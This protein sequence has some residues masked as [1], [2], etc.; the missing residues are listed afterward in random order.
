MAGPRH[1]GRRPLVHDVAHIDPLHAALPGG[2]KGRAGGVVEVSLADQRTVGVC[3]FD[4][5][6][7]RQRAQ[8]LCAYLHAVDCTCGIVYCS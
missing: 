4:G 6:C 8:L 3:A 7:Q 2:A 1:D 5:L